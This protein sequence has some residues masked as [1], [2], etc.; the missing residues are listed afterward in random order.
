MSK[1][2]IIDYESGNVASVFNAFQSF[3]QD[4][5]LIISNDLKDI[6]NSDFLILPGVGAFADCMEGLK[7][8]DG[9]INEIKQQV[10]INKKPFLGICVGMQVLA[11]TGFENGEH[12]GLDFINGDVK[13]IPQLNNL[14]VPHMG[15]NNI[16]V[17]NQNSLLKN[18]S[19]NE[20]FYFANS[21]YFIAKN[22]QNISA[23]V[24]H[25]VEIPAIINRNNIFGVQ[26]HPEK[27]GEVG[28]KI[29][30]NFLN[31]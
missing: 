7:K 30:Q 10:L 3:N 12:K 18:I 13:P 16:V 5:Q 11:K 14:K 23:K 25:G 20:H 27:S 15:W 4:N 31:Q 22:T 29:L 2:C 21:Y 9:L 24:K 6:K 26:F 8:I 1:I 19:E 17:S 28:L